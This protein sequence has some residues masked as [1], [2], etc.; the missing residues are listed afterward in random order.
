M[1]EINHVFVEQTTN[2]TTSSTTYGDVSGAVITDAQ[3]TDG[4]KYLIVIT[5]Q[6]RNNDTNNNPFFRTVHGSTEFEGSEF[7]FNR[8]FF[9]AHRFRYV[10]Y[11]VWTAVASEDVKIQFRQS[12][13]GTTEID[14]ISM[15]AINLSD[16]LTENTDWHFAEDLTDHA[17]AATFGSTDDASITFTPNGT[18]D[19]FVIATALLVPS[20]SG[21]TYETRI[22][23]TGG[24]SDTAV[25][26]V[27]KANDSNDSFVQTVMKVYTPTSTSTTF[28]CES[29]GP[30]GDDRV[31]NS[32]FALNLNKFSQ[33]N[34]DVQ[35]TTLVC[36]ATNAF[37]TSTEMA[38][39]SI[40]PDITGDVWCLVF[41][42][43][44]SANQFKYRMQVE[45]ADQP[46][47]QTSDAYDQHG[48][49]G[50]ADRHMHMMQSIENLASGASRATDLD[51]TSTTANNHKNRLAMMVTMELAAAGGPGPSSQV[52]IIG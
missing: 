26:H 36:D 43:D 2:Q 23:A 29:K 52:V 4:K 37:A 35:P 44:D 45:N 47:G 34:Q 18:D 46:A 13:S 27:H 51:V 48:G 10:W 9:G 21:A 50:A 40:T 28:E 39:T 25:I 3:L 33:H 6:C 22:N 8:S 19:W 20:N 15:V 49:L 1:A 5:A 17:L 42:T 32:V 12:T 14:H 41:G 30:T 11:T 7:S 31:Y 38:S 24:V 16:D